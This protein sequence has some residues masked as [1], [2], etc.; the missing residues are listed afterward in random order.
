MVKLLRKKKVP[1]ETGRGWQYAD[2]E[3]S[4]LRVPPN[5]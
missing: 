1:V 4:D 2:R 3:E 5:L